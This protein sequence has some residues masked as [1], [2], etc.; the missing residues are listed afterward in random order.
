VYDNSEQVPYGVHKRVNTYTIS[1]TN[2]CS[3]EYLA[4]FHHKLSIRYL[5]F[6]RCSKAKHDT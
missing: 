5:L 2:L 3:N 6:S 4:G 1:S